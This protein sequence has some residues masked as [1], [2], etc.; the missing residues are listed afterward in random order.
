M[1][2]RICSCSC[3]KVLWLNKFEFLEIFS[4]AEIV[5]RLANYQCFFTLVSEFLKEGLFTLYTVSLFWDQKKP[6][7]VFQ[8]EELFATIFE[9]SSQDSI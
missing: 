8:T 4:V 7:K 5:K 3:M 6:K 9:V 1:Y 2:T